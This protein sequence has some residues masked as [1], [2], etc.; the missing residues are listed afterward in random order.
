M[1][2]NPDFML[3]LME[4]VLPTRMVALGMIVVV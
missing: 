1:Y 4:M 2:G 3:I